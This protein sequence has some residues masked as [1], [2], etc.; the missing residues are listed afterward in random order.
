M[1]LTW[2][3]VRRDLLTVKISTSLRKPSV[4]KLPLSNDD[5]RLRMRGFFVD[6]VRSVALANVARESA[7]LLVMLTCCCSGT[8]IAVCAA[9]LSLS[10][11]GKSGATQKLDSRSPFAP[12][13][14]NRPHPETM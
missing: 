6:V 12:R 14:S 11:S 4:L 2:P 9:V 8:V 7:I 3:A 5:L 1:R 10:N 13:A